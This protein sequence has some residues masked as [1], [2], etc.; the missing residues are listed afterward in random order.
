MALLIAAENDCLSD[1]TS[2]RERIQRERAEEKRRTAAE[3]EWLKLVQQLQSAFAGMAYGEIRL[4]INE[5]RLKRIYKT[6]NIII[7]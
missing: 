6:E 1:R 7:E 2:D 4:V 5:G 3:A